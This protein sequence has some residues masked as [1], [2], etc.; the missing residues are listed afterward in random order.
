MR[1][2]LS[3]LEHRIE[4]IN[5]AAWAAIGLAVGFAAT[6]MKPS[7]DRVVMLE[8]MAVAAFGSFIGGEFLTAMLRAN[9]KDASITLL[10]VVLAGAC[11]VAALLLLGLMRRSVGPLKSRKP[12]RRS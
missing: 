4:S 3:R 11:S 1:G 2:P 6:R 5:I 9:P 7:G 12:K 8:T 10:A